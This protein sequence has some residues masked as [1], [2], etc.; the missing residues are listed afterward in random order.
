MHVIGTAGHVDHGKSAL[1]RALTGINPDRL[2]EEQE[3][4][5]TIDLGFAWL[6]LP[7]GESVGIV[8]VPG[9]RDFIENMLAGVG[10]IDAALFVVAAD[11]GVMPQTREHLA[12]LDLLET[13]GG[14]IAL[15]KRDLIHDPEWL[16]LVTAEVSEAVDGTVLADAPIIPV[17]AHT[18][19]GLEAL[20][21]ALQSALAGRPPHPDRG[22]PR[23]WVDRVFTISGFGTVVTGTL[24][25]GALAVG[26]EVVFLPEGLRGRVRG[27]QT[28]KAKIE[29]ALPGSRVAVN[30]SGVSKDQ[31]RRG[32]LLTIPGWLRGT[33]LADV[34]FRH[35]PD[36][37][38]PLRHNTEVKLFVGAA[39][40]VA[41]ARLLDAPELAPGQ[42]GWLQL[43]LERETPSCVATAS[44]CAIPRRRR[45]S[46][47]AW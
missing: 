23:L 30:V 20:V 28:H 24:T 9:H 4:E 29:R 42:E 36:A 22:R 13:Q 38:R 31:V 35:L 3:R 15:T 46:A 44:S 7:N 32:D 39:E 18:G 34:R 19:E 5:M 10:G 2:R 14:V 26:Q 8:D 25:D 47:G 45:P 16:E 11:E 27:L 6:T 41:R 37:S 40:V 43:R 1:V 12:I 21:T 33:V 17:S